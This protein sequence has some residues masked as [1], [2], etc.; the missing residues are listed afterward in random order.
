MMKARNEVVELPLVM[1]VVGDALTACRSRLLAI[2]VTVAR[3]VSTW[4][5]T[6]RAGK[7]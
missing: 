7:K 5:P 1:Q 6:W 2:G 3:R 4:R